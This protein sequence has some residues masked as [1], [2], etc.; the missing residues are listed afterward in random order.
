MERIWSTHHLLFIISVDD[1]FP[2]C[3]LN[4][5]YFMVPIADQKYV[6]DKKINEM[7][8]ML[9]IYVNSHVQHLTV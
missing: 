5:K 3:F 2:P 8:P 9:I 1:F 6:P 4:L 7:K